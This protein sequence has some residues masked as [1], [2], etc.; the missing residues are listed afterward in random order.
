MKLFMKKIL[1]IL[2][3]GCILLPFTASGFAYAESSNT[4]I[5]QERAGNFAASFAIN[6]FNN[7]SSENHVFEDENGNPVR[8]AYSSTYTLPTASDGTYYLS[9]DSWIDFVYANSLSLS[10]SKL[11]SSNYGSNG[12]YEQIKV[13]DLAEDILKSKDE[14]SNDE[15]KSVSETTVEL[16]NAGKIKPGDILLTSE[17]DYLLYVG[18][19]RVIYA[20][21]A[22]GIHPTDTGALKYD[23]IQN[24]FVEVRR[25]LTKD[26]E[27]STEEENEQIESKQEEPKYGVKEIYRISQTSLN[28]WQVTESK[29]NLMFN[30]RGYYDKDNQYKGLPEGRYEGST[31]KSLIG[32]I[33]EGIKAF[34][35][36]LVNLSAF[37]L[38]AVVVG[39]VDLIETFFQSSIL[40]LSGHSNK[41]SFVDEISGISHTS[42]SGDRVTMESILFNK[43]PLTDANF[44]N[45]KTAG[46]YELTE[47]GEPISWLYNI[48]KNLAEVYGMCRNISIGIMLFVLMYVGIRQAISTI[49]KR[50]ADYKKMLTA[51]F[52]GLCIVLFIHIFMYLVLFVNDQLVNIFLEQNAAAASQILGDGT[53][54]LTLYDAIRTKAYSWD[55]FDGTAGL[56]MYIVMVYFLIRYLFIYLKRM[57]SVYVLAIY[58]S[59]IGVKYAIE[60]SSGRR[61]SNSFARWM[62]DFMFNVLL[63]SIHCLIYVTL[64]SVAVEMAMHSAGGIIVAIIVCQFI[65]KAD[66]IFMKIFNVKGSL[67]DDTNKDPKV[68]GM[69]GKAMSALRTGALVYGV[70]KFGKQ[71]F[72]ADTG[73]RPFIRFAMNY[74]EGDTEKQTIARG[75]AKRLNRKA[76]FAEWVYKDL[77]FLKHRNGDPIRLFALKKNYAIQQNRRE[78]YHK[79]TQT[80]SYQVKKAL[81]AA[82]TAE[83]NL[84]K[85]RFTRV[86]NTAKNVVGGGF[87]AVATP[88]AFTE[89]FAPGVAAILAAKKTLTASSRKNVKLYRRV[90]TNEHV[91]PGII[92]EMEIKNKKAAKDYK[93]LADKQSALSVVADVHGNIDSIIQQL[94]SQSGMSEKEKFSKLKSTMTATQKTSI[95]GTKVRN[96]VDNLH[97]DK[98]NSSDID[99]ALEELKYILE[100]TKSDIIIDE[101]MTERI[102]QAIINSGNNIDEVEGKE[103]A[104]I[105]TEA[106]NELDVVPVV[107]GGKVLDAADAIS[108]DKLTLKIIREYE[109]R[110]GIN[111]TESERNA[112]KKRMKTISGIEKMSESELINQ[113]TIAM[114]GIN[115]DADRLR[116]AT[117]TVAAQGVPKV[118]DKD[119]HALM[120]KVEQKIKKK[121]IDVNITKENGSSTDLSQIEA[122]VKS[123][124]IEKQKARIAGD[125][126][127]TREMAIK[128][129]KKIISEESNSDLAQLIYEALSEPGTVPI[130][131]TDDSNVQNLLQETSKLMRKINEINQSN[132]AKNKE[133][134]ISYGEVV[135]EIL[136]N[137]KKEVQ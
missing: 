119:F 63:Q 18:G 68:R 69:F 24:Y 118:G 28:D 19:T 137:Y 2:M 123:R 117:E 56:V 20:T 129:K 10:G 104:K 80:N 107:P 98:L 13:T 6:F 23:Y 12:A 66:E 115:L 29:V 9:K 101:A 88:A 48:R 125:P 15:E 7:W 30:D 78:L 55:F 1:V 136:E 110:T 67:L 46:G 135:H 51:W 92:G 8:T 54:S 84:R 35:K 127:K 105:L 61:S 25:Y 133:S 99:G 22:D 5:T 79:I 106:I 72:A 14:N 21:P 124:V 121:G 45:F 131:S 134:A 43:L 86:V 74:K 108:V 62:K 64:M 100:K 95:S 97:K 53:E 83:K 26:D 128:K 126:T 65:L 17:N 52:T 60:K 76:A 132:I 114:D 58:G 102:K 116:E 34:F 122:T 40:K 103:F 44:F 112:L 90:N 41:V 120:K 31:H 96:A 27:N 87:A 37:L 16:M 111:L 3:I 39:W 38:R 91:S 130:V 77:P 50:K 4:P 94:H 113:V 81:Y 33:W 89:G 70:F 57:I 49:A 75:E 36:F 85:Q 59:V 42:Y 93:K 73:V 47:N 32:S 109:N 71:L 82:I 11:P